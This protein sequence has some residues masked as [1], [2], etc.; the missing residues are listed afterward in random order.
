MHQFEGRRNRAKAWCFDNGVTREQIETAWN[1]AIK[2]GNQ[3][4]I[5]LKNS[6]CIWEDINH[7]LIMQLL[8]RYGNK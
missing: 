6:G 4:I 1:N 5:Q 8:E 7:V 2:A 3:K